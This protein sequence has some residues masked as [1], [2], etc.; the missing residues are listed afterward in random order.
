MKRI[1]GEN[2]Y[3][4]RQ[5]TRLAPTHEPI[6]RFGE[7]AN[8]TSGPVLEGAD[9]LLRKQVGFEGQ[10]KI[11]PKTFENYRRHIKAMISYSWKKA[12]QESD[13]L[14]EVEEPLPL[15]LACDM[16][17]RSDIGMNTKLTYRSALLSLC[18]EHMNHDNSIR[19]IKL[20]NDWY[21]AMKEAGLPKRRG[22]RRHIHELDYKILIRHLET[23]NSVWAFRA[24]WWLQ[25]GLATGLRPTEWFSARWFDE[26]LNQ[27]RVINAKEKIS[28][29]K[30][31]RGD[32][33]LEFG[34]AS[35]RT[36]PVHDS[37]E[38]AMVQNHMH[39]LREYIHNSGLEAEEA[40][41]KYYHSVRQAVYRAC[42]SIWKGEK[43]YSLYDMRGQF[44][45]NKRSAHG[46]VE[47]ARLM[48]HCCHRTPSR[49]SYGVAQQ[50]HS[51]FKGLRPVQRIE[52]QRKKQIEVPNERPRFSGG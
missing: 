24:I 1:V 26:G 29:L 22:K 10:I 38:R 27:L 8:N 49:A 45:A 16:V 20:L 6:Y 47:A 50:A 33:N 19:A 14:S 4:V 30:E 5:A 2:L 35:V 28:K 34:L 51:A 12:A 23:Q 42:N 48:G 40:F 31:Q 39:A 13:G 7:E 17:Q 41:N 21:S 3:L 15:Q 46:P 52:I 37:L 9:A 11:K 32:S 43:L 18:V 44:S 36:I 25:A